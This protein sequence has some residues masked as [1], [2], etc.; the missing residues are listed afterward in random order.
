MI[1]LR[2]YIRSNQHLAEPIAS[3]SVTFPNDI[4][5]REYPLF[6]PLFSPHLL[7]K[8]RHLH[9]IK[10]IIKLLNLIEILPLHFSPRVTLLA[11]VAL[12]RKQQLI[13]HD[14]MRINL[15]AIQLLNHALGLVQRQE[16][17]DANAHEGRHVRVLELRV[18]FPNR[19][20][21]A[22]H[23]LDQVVKILASRKTAARADDGI[24]HGAKLRAELRKLGEGFFEH[25]G[26]LEEAKGVARGR[27]V[28]DDD[29]VGEGFDLFEHFGKGHGFVDAGDLLHV[30]L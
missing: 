2:W 4:E 29:F 24:Q 17:R 30:R 11:I 26:E 12:L 8:Q 28:E 5:A 13:H 18:D 27:S 10:F 3:K 16:L 9:H 20:T 7:H 6:Q 25:G 15:V 14:A 21:K 22:L 19:R 1:L 23:A